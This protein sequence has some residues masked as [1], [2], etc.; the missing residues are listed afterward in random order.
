MPALPK[1]YFLA[2]K[3]QTQQTSSGL[4][5]LFNFFVSS[6]KQ[7][8]IFDPVVFFCGQLSVQHAQPVLKKSGEMGGKLFW[9]MVEPSYN[10]SHFSVF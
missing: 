8:T 5:L 6:Q 9:K 3:V 7:S 4:G 1:R 2:E 10:S